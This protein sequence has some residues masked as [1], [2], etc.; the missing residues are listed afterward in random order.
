MKGFAYKIR[1]ARNHLISKQCFRHPERKAV[2]G[3]N[4]GSFTWALLSI[5][6]DNT[7]RT[8]ATTTT[9]SIF[10]FWEQLFS[11]NVDNIIPKDE[12]VI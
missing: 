3:V 1:I 7:T 9:D 8:A 12:V 2:I 11:A 6:L 5:K 10:I 4:C